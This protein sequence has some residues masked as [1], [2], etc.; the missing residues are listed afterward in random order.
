MKIGII[1]WFSKFPCIPTIF[2]FIIL[3][4]QL[5]EYVLLSTGRSDLPGF[6]LSTPYKMEWVRSFRLISSK[7]FRG[8][9]PVT[10]NYLSSSFKEQSPHGF[11]ET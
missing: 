2:H 4:L 6:V 5:R 7:S 9:A 1:S 8:L 10:P 11:Y 3:S